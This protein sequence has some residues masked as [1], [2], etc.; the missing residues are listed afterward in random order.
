MYWL[1][2]IFKSKKSWS[3]QAQVNELPSSSNFLT[4]LSKCFLII[5]KKLKPV[6]R[7]KF[8]NNEQYIL[9]P[10]HPLRQNSTK[11]N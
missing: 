3:G 4:E 10:D 5:K 11:G 9:T 1:Y 6:D 8:L 2:F 7:S